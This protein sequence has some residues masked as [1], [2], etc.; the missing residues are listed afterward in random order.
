MPIHR[1]RILEYLRQ[2]EGAPP[3]VF[4]GRGDILKD[5]LTTA[6][7]SAGQPKM[8]RIVQGAPGAGKSS[9]LHEMQKRWTGEKG[10]PRVVA[11]SSTDITDDPSVGVG[12]VL[13]AWAMEEAAWKRT[14]ADRLERLR[15]V[16]VG[17]GGLSLGFSDAEVP[18]TLRMV[19]KRHPARAGSVPVVVAVDEAQRFA[20]D[21]TTPEARFLQTIHD[22]SSGLPLVLVLAGLSDTAE[23]ARGMHLTRGFRIHETEPL[24]TAEA[25]DFM[26]RLALHFGLDTSRHN[27]RLND[28][29]DLCDGWPRHLRH[30]GET[31]G[32]TAMDVDGDMDLMDWTGIRKQTLGLRQD[33][34]RDQCTSVMEDA[35]NLVAAVMD[36]LP[37]SRDGKSGRL[38]RKDILDLIDMHRDH[39]GS[40]P[41]GWRLPEG[42]TSRRFLDMLIHQGALYRNRSGYI[43][44]PIPSF[45]T[46]LIEVG[47]EP[48]GEPDVRNDA[49]DDDGTCPSA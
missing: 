27:A 19:A 45:R 16:G 29:A 33:Y 24:S 41:N 17:P 32:K 47:T 6:K 10:T 13:E 48:H 30:A 11:L 36:G 49:T 18:G 14:L 40:K 12:A 5:I 20:G 38:R 26:R 37:G 28:L 35:E 31:L 44:S 21:E 46:Y 25:R 9:L 3:P 43:H 1:D 22:G 23:K 15:G 2:G 8:T 7:D 42:M 39:D 34:C 4:V